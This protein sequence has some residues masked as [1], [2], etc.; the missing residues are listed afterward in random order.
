MQLGKIKLLAVTNSVR[1][2]AAPDTPT[3]AEAG[4]PVLSID[5]LVGLF[6]PPDMPMQLRERIAA[7]VKAVMA[8]DPVI[9]ERLTATGQFINPGGPA[10]FAAA[11]ESQRARLA[12]AAAAVGIKAKQ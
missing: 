7:D 12:T 10:E 9:A 6:G 5:G 4:Y 1:A 8:A 11:I 2:P 3:A